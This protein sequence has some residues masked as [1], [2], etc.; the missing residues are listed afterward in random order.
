MSKEDTVGDPTQSGGSAR[1][2]TEQNEV[3]D[4]EER[5]SSSDAVGADAPIQDEET[6]KKILQNSTAGGQTAVGRARDAH[7]GDQA[8]RIKDLPG[9]SELAIA[10]G[11]SLPKDFPDHTP[12]A[13]VGAQAQ[14]AN[15]TTNGSLP[16]NMVATPSGLV[17]ASAVSADPAIAAQRVQE[18]MDSLKAHTHRTGGYDRLSRAQIETMSA[19]DLR[20]VAAQRGYD[21]GEYAGSRAT[22]KRFIA[23]QHEDD[24]LE[25]EREP[26]EP[27]AETPAGTET[28]E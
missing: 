4:A 22:R 17:P 23:A 3:S 10:G 11:D 8:E 20:A 5:V 15:Y 6:R 25:G 21:I 19:G 16:L 28:A 27:A 9:G 13:P 1:T 26:D 2:G 24:D 18:S 12:G 7:L 14:P